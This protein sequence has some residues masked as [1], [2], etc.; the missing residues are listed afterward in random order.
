V[1]FDHLA[2]FLGVLEHGSFT[3]AAEVLGLSQSTVSFHVKALETSVGVKLIDRG[4]DG[5]DTTA[6]GRVLRRYAAQ[7]LTLRN[8][9]ESAL[10]AIDEGLTGYVLVAAST[11]VGE[12][13]LPRSLARLRESHVGVSVSVAVSDSRRAIASLL[14]GEADVA[15]VGGMPRDRRLT[16]RPFAHDEIVL[17]GPGAGGVEPAADGSLASTP[18][19]L[20]REGSGTREAVADVLAAALANARAGTTVEVGSTEAVKRCVEAGLG[21]GFVSRIAISDE[22]EAGRLRIVEVRGLPI[23]REF[24]IALRKGATLPPAAAALVEILTGEPPP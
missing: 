11:I 18:L 23:R 3:R 14:A 13:L 8:E 6:H 21:L 15:L 1:E 16:V 17:V 5:V 20:R 7:L 2:T 12:Y 10:R 24:H 4:R 19:V 22:L 9:A